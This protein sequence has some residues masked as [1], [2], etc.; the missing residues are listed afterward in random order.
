[1]NSPAT[2]N[3]IEHRPLWQ[4]RPCP[5]NART[6]SEAQTRQ[7]AKSIQEFGFVN[8][9][10]IAPDGTII[11]GHARF[12]A[13]SYLCMKSLPV[14]VIGHLSETQRRALVIADNQLAL[15]AG[16]NADLLRA[17]L[18][19]LEAEKF[20]LDVIGFD[21]EELNRLVTEQDQLVEKE[22]QEL[23]HADPELTLPRLPVSQPGDLWILGPNRFFCGEHS[24][25]EALGFADKICHQWQRLTGKSAVLDND[26]RTFEDLAA[27]R[28]TLAA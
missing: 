3:G 26:Q 28:R 24:T 1:M 15:N 16:W 22:L 6:H 18:I 27:N 5:N 23:T 14:I 13:A 17:E 12:A 8:P 2:V 25:E 21:E 20:D 10:L 11:A 19:A 7:I 4:L 9:I